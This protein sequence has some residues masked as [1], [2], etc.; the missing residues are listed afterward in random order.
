MARNNVLLANQVLTGTAGETESRPSVAFGDSD[1]GFYEDRDDH[2]G[3]TLGGVSR[4]FF[5]GSSFTEADGTV[6]GGALAD[7][8]VKGQNILDGAITNAD[9]SG[10]AGIGLNKLMDGTQGEGLFYNSASEVSGLAVGNTGQF[11]KTQ[12]AGANPVWDD[13]V[14]TG[15]QRR[16]IFSGSS[17]TSNAAGVNI[18]THR[19][20]AGTF[21][22]GQAL[23]V[24]GLINSDSD[25]TVRF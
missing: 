5:S 9:I 22:S 16:Y 14:S 15:L 4:F 10:L 2:L 12:G 17:G 18:G 1:T 13:V 8:A 20:P 6:I 3:V 19:V 11:L 24:F 7:D 25:G 23:K 21:T